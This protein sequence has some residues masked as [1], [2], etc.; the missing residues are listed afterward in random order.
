[1]PRDE[2]H[3]GFRRHGILGTTP[4]MN[5]QRVLGVILLALGMLFFFIGRNATESMNQGIHEG[6]TGQYT[7]RTTWYLLVG[8]AMTLVG[9]AMALLGG[10]GRTRS[11]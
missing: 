9:G 5:S 3:R 2:T 1:M 4:P 8:L 6:L 11:T 10:G 7:D